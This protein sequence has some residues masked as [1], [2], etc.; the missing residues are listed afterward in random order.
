[1]KRVVFSIILI[2]FVFSTGLTQQLSNSTHLTEARVVLNPAFTSTGT[3]L[4]I[5][6]LF[7]LQ[8][9]GFTGAPFSGITTLQYPIQKYNMS[10]GGILH[11]DKTGPISKAGIQLNYAYK[12]KQ[13]LSRYGQLSLG[14]SGDFQ[15]YSFNGSDLIYNDNND[16]LINTDASGRFFAS[17]GSGFYYLSNTR[18]FKENTFFVGASV[19]QIFTTKVL[20]NEFDQTRLRHFH[21][22]AGGRFYNYDTFLEPMI[23]A[24]IVKPDIIDVLYGVK[25]EKEDTFWAGLGYASSGTVAFQGGIIIDKF[26][27]RLSKLRIGGLASWGVGTSIAKAGPGIEFYVGYAL[28]TK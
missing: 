17:F 2:C 20:V 8:W 10:V 4:I 16:L 21:F 5:N 19:S 28:D 26:G 27:N 24:N 9:L 12:L 6:G 18:E 25:F 3:E 15:Q 23:T 11:F 7:R 14:I 22:N 1:M 13:F